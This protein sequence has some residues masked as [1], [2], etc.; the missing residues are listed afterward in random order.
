MNAL[1][2]FLIKNCFRIG[3]VDSILF[4]RKMAKIYLDAKYMLIILFLV[5]LMPHF[6]KNLARS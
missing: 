3:K 4:T 1:G 2:I 5:L 6:V